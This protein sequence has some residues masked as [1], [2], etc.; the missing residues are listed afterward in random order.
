VGVTASRASLA[1]ELSSSSMV[2]LGKRPHEASTDGGSHPRFHAMLRRSVWYKP[3]AFSIRSLSPLS[4]MGL[5]LA[6]IMQRFLHDCAIPDSGASPGVARESSCRRSPLSSPC[7]PAQPSGSEMGESSKESEY[8]D[9][10]DYHQLL[11]DFC[12]V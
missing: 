7:V 4:Y 10:A 5:N 1:L 2:V 3:F 9:D 6:C 8:S 12:K 11:K